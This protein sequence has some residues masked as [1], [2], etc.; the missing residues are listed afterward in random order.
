MLRYGFPLLASLKGLRGGPLDVFASS[1]DRRL[2]RRLLADYEA[3]LERLLAGLT[4]ERL[5]LA[6][7]IASVPD[8]IRGY[9]HVKEAAAAAARPAE[10]AL[11]A[12][13]HAAPASLP[14]EGRTAPAARVGDSE[15]VR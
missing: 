7:K 3:G 6:V 15:A 2:E 4:P 10:G 9:G 13:W 14:G 1:P 8:A 12:E 5:S 11:W